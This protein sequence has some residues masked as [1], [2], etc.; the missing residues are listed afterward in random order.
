MRRCVVGVAI[1]LGFV[2]ALVALPQRA[3]AALAP[4]RVTLTMTERACKASRRQLQ[5]GAAMFAIVNR[6]RRARRFAVAGRRSQFLRRG[7]RAKLKVTFRR[8][9]RYPFTCTA[10][11]LSKRRGVKRGVIVVTT[12]AVRPNPRP[13][14]PPPPPPPAPNP[15]PGP[16]PPPP[17][18]GPPPPPPPHILGVRAGMG[19]A[20]E[21]YNRNTGQTFVPRGSTFA[22][23]QLNQSVF[24]PS[25]FIVGSYNHGAAESALVAMQ[26]EGYNVVRIFLDVRCTVGCLTNTLSFDHLSRPYLANVADFMQ[27]AKAHGIF[28]LVSLEALPYGSQYET[29]WRTRCCTTF[30]A[31]NLTYLTT[32][33]VNAHRQFWQALHA[34]L[35]SV[36]APLDYVWGYEILSEAFFREASPPLSLASGLVTTA[37]GSTYDMSSPAQKQLMMDENLVYW[38]DQ[39]RGAILA[40]DPTA[41]VSVGSLWPKSPNPARAFDSRVIR[42]Q[43][44]YNSSLDF[45]GLHLH[46]GVQLTYDDYMENYEL[47]TPV[48][49]PVVLG[50]FGAFQFAYPTVAD[51]ERALKGV[52]ADSCASGLDGWIFF[53]WDTTEFGSGEAPMWNGMSSG[54]PI[55]QALGSRLRPDPCVPV[56]GAGNLAL[57]KPVTAS[58]SVDGPAANAVDGLMAN[59]WGAGNYPPQW[60]E[61]DLGA[62]VTIGR[63]RLFIAQT[64]SGATTHRVDGRA[65]TGDAWAPLHEFSGNT[66]DNGVLEHI[67]GSPWT[68]VRYVRVNTPASVSWVSWRE[69]EIYG[70]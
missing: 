21:F 25:T 57:G 58:A 35:R 2:L 69:I 46:P 67:P 38:A 16:P 29:L 12:R 68:N 18:P 23:R 62:P 51:A 50:A 30:G 39:V 43:P 6:S 33:G 53:S 13:Q 7:R 44:L 65:T 37:N 5:V 61:I 59:R 64:P 47:T 14:P 70:P 41:L 48:A 60:I 42:A 54:G 8:A 56:P 63:I 17:P 1:G 49:K 26:A 24:G 4:T 10:R 32:E 22:R 66:S 55:G 45:V 19:G 3:Q 15:P 27:R 28:T 11:G 36:S 34:A 52:Q 40:V 31:E 9:G 20:D